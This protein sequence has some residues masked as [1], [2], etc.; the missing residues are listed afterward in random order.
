M[1]K[2][3]QLAGLLLL[4]F[5]L[6]SGCVP[7]EKRVLKSS[8][9]TEELG[10][11]GIIDNLIFPQTGNSKRISGVK[12]IKA[13][14]TLQLA[15]IEGAGIIRH[16][17]ITAMCKVP[18]I[19]GCLV[20]RMYWDDEQ[21]PSVQAPLGDFF[22]VGF[23][24]EVEF[25]S[26]ALEMFP[27]S[28]N[29]HSAL[30]CYF[31]MPFHKSA[32]ITIENRS[33]RK[34]NMFFWHIDYDELP[35]LPDNVLHFHACW[36]RENPVTLHQPYTIL[37]AKG[38]GHYIGTVLN[39]HLLGPGAWVE[40]G[41]NFYIDESTEPVL[42]GTGAEDY[43]GH[44]WGFRQ[45]NNALFHGTS[46][47][48]KDA[49]MTAYRFHLL[50]PVKFNKSIR[51]IMRCHGADVGDRQDDYSSV[52]YWYQTE[53]HLPFGELPPLDYDYLEVDEE[54]RRPFSPEAIKVPPEK[55]PAGKNLA[56]GFKEYR[57]SGH[58]LPETIGAMALDG[59][60]NTK[61]CEIDNPDN[62]WL[63]VDLG[64]LKKIYGF[65]L[66]NASL[67]DELE[68][69]NTQA[70]S[71]YVADSLNGEWKLL[72]SSSTTQDDIYISGEK[73]IISIKLN[74]PV[75]ARCIKI[76]VTVPGFLDTIVRLPE[77][78]IYGD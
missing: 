17:W 58:F 49:K 28:G 61:W 59:N 34:V 8:S 74:K 29:N 53:P 68:G 39:Y 62:H 71:I 23:G 47:G 11:G 52:A 75:L 73:E 27:A 20:L 60:I 43:F 18:Q 36:R 69:F 55:M 64:E 56:T 12:D 14:E 76:H 6:S 50:D 2:K 5:V 10:R 22:G 4:I 24:K 21:E 25:K 1:R 19:Y 63:A 33:Q 48:P 66:K 42:P 3:I 51:V 67:A 38:R 30:N 65:I 70:F 31:P 26:F 72:T 54:F 46:Y 41:D 44:G 37:Y 45:Q 40:G 78:E 9:A 15:E 16:I 77:F 13:G 7:Y 32:R 35:N 57:E